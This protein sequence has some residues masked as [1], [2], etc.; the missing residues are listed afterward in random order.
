MGFNASVENPHM[1]TASHAWHSVTGRLQPY[2]EEF[3]QPSATAKI[4]KT[5]IIK[6][7]IK[8]LEN[9][10]IEVEIS[11]TIFL[12]DGVLRRII[13][14]HFSNQPATCIRYENTVGIPAENGKILS[15]PLK[16]SPLASQPPFLKSLTK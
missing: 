14:S 1:A 5:A 11:N 2:E 6:V 4:R 15:M 16:K 3:I 9:A 12:R 10:C 8:D 7:A 13:S